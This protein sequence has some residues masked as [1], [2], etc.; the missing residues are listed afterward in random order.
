MKSDY[1]LHNLVWQYQKR[2]RR[3]TLQRAFEKLG[4]QH[5]CCSKFIEPIEAVAIGEYR[6]RDSCGRNAVIDLLD[7][8][9]RGECPDAI[10][11]SAGACGLHF[12]FDCLYRLANW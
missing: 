8:N 10:V 3:F 2:G 1:T 11:I 12:R 7:L 9:L 6:N 4:S 5:S